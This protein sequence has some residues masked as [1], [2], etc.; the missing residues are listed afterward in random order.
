MTST[1]KAAR[2]RHGTR[3]AAKAAK[4]RKG[5]RKTFGTLPYSAV[6]GNAATFDSEAIT[7]RAAKEQKWVRDG[8]GRP[9]VGRVDVTR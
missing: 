5:K 4:S 6:R 7:Q 9:R 2:K 3:F 1:G 8:L